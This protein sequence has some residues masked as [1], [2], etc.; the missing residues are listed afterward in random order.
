MLL[1]GGKRGAPDISWSHALAVAAPMQAAETL[2]ELGAC[3]MTSA[4]ADIATA[5]AT[6]GDKTA[7]GVNVEAGAGRR[8]ACGEPKLRSNTRR[9]PRSFGGWKTLT[10]GNLKLPA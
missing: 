8:V 6:T 7:Q 10:Q 1:F 5:R 3:V 9:T 4:V 2:L